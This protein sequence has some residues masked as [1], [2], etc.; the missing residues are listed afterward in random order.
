M[1]PPGT[2]HAISVSYDHDGMPTVRHTRIDA[3]TR[4]VISENLATFTPPYGPEASWQE[5]LFIG[6]SELLERLTTGTSPLPW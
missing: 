3:A 5:H 6:A 2:Y 4:R 1:Y